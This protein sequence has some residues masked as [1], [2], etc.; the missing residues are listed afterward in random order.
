L[1]EPLLRLT[2]DIRRDRQLLRRHL[3]KLRSV[4][5]DSDSD[6]QLL[7]HVSLT[8]HNAYTAVENILKRIAS[9]FGG[10]PDGERW[11]IDLLDGM[12]VEIDQRPRVLSSPVHEALAELLAFRHYL[13]HGSVA[14]EPDAEK[15]AVLLQH[16]LGVEPGLSEDLD[17]FEA[18]LAGL[19]GGA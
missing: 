1:S 12:L 4:R 10:V 7:A 18:Y 6:E 15:L 5:L 19:T 14:H 9:A 11:H 3:D 8:L 2:E 17:R 16:A 13:I